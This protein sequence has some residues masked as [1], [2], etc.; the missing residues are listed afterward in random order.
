MGGGEG[1]GR[2]AGT[3][4][5]TRKPREL[6][7]HLRIAQRSVARHAGPFDVHQLGLEKEIRGSPLEEAGAVTD[8][9]RASCRGT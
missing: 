7:A 3:E 9:L 2:S 5:E 4:A 6:A 8:P 1:G